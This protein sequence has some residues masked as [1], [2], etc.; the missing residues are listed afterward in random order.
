MQKF[1]FH[2][3]N[4]H[5]E[6]VSMMIHASDVADARRQ[7]Q[8][9]GLFPLKFDA[10]TPVEKFKPF[11]NSV[12]SKVTRVVTCKPLFQ[13]GKFALAIIKTPDRWLNLFTIDYE[14]ENG[15]RGQWSMASRKEMPLVGKLT[16]DAVVIVATVS[17]PDGLKI[18]LTSEYR[19]PIGDL[20]YGFPAGLIDKN[21]TA[22]D[23]A[24]RELKEET[25]LDIVRVLHTSPP[26]ISSAGMSD[27]SVA[28][29]FV[30]ASGTLSIDGQE[31]AEQIRPYLASM[32]EIADLCHRRGKYKDVM[33]SAKAWPVLFGYLAVGKFP[34]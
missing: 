19:Y 12:I 21:E 33:I 5:G 2:G 11:Y 3:M 31:S 9:Q 18:L 28:F 29:V 34:T 14:S 1:I 13:I 20:E 22:T 23:A 24:R 27:E 4:H 6:T 26:L 30:E 10:Q 16:A 25:G 15:T 32:E 17:H 8:Q 7:L